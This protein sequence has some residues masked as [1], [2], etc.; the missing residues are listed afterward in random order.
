MESFFEGNPGVS[1]R[2]HWRFTFDSRPTNL[3]WSWREV[4]ANG[5]TAQWSGPF[6]ELKSAVNDAVRCGFSPASGEWMVRG[7]PMRRRRD[8]LTP[9]ANLPIDLQT[10]TE[11]IRD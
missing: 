7:V 11:S 5:G 10:D 6:S 4:D 9:T 3:S 2:A 1:D 8:A